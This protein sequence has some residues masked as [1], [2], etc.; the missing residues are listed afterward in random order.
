MERRLAAILAADVAGYSRLIGADEEGTL[1]ALH[2]HRDE[3]IDPLLAKRGGRIA[4]TGGDS[5]LIEF[6]SAV[7]AVRMAIAMQEGMRARNRDTSK[8]R[9]IEYR[10]GINVGDVVVEGDD[11]LG[12]GVN[13]AARL[14]ALAPPSGIVFGRSVRDYVRDKMELNLADLGEVQVKNIARPVRAFHVLQDGEIPVKVPRPSKG[15]WRALAAAAVALMA[16]FGG[17]VYWQT[18]RP[19]FEPADPERMAFALSEEPSVAVL[20]FRNLSGDP[21][22]EYLSDGIT[23]AITSTLALSPDLIVIAASSTAAFKGKSIPTN[24][25]A[26]QLGARYILNGSVQKSE[27]RLRITT[28]LADAIDGR[29]LWSEKYDRAFRDIFAIQDDISEKVLKEIQVELTFE[30]KN[31][32][33]ITQDFDEYLAYL[34]WRNLFTKF[35]REGHDAAI[36]IA[37]ELLGENPDS[38][39]AHEMMGMSHFGR[40]LINISDDPAEDLRISRKYYERAIEF[41]P[42]RAN[43]QWLGWVDLAERKFE[44]A[45]RNADKGLAIAPNDPVR[46]RSAGAIKAMSGQHVEGLRLMKRAIRRTPIGS[47]WVITDA[48]YHLMLLGEYEEARQ[49]SLDLLEKNVRD[50]RAHHSALRFLAAISVWEGDHDEARGYIDRLLEI[51]PDDDVQDVFGRRAREKN[52]EFAEKFAE[53]L[54]VAG[55]PERDR[56]SVAE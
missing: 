50:A 36:A 5:L 46:L 30:S 4:N 8:D 53:A 21:S 51:H 26:E 34:K 49:I 18:Q 14:E 39:V 7:E 27:D 22:A 56:E 13:I 6:P 20:P 12:D 24:E 40:T 54:R 19:D 17:A 47:E 29:L 16:L 11:L 38:A 2:A 15:R 48:T 52:Q 23:E 41:D 42:E 35:T 3:L 10:V 33:L 45:I 43:Y 37:R 1:S 9:R 32:S 31:E 28:Q 44:A 25:I 55:L